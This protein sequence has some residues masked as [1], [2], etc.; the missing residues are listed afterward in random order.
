MTNDDAIAEFLARGGKV[1]R[2]PPAVAAPTCVELSTDARSQLA[3]HRAELDARRGQQMA[4]S[5]LRF[6][7]MFRPWRR[8]PAVASYRGLFSAPRSK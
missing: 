7:V 4:M 2:C 1:E 8:R 6:D 5:R 3:L